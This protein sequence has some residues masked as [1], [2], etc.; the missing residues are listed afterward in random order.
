MKAAVDESGLPVAGLTAFR[1][2]SCRGRVDPV[3]ITRF[4][5]AHE[6]HPPNETPIPRPSSRCLVVD[7]AEVRQLGSG[8]TVPDPAQ[9]SRPMATPPHEQ[10]R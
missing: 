6:F 10:L 7:R 5:A 1:P 8:A 4:G 3:V 9:P 2:C